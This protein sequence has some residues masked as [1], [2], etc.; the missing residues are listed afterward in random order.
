MAVSELSAVERALD[1]VEG[2]EDAGSI[3][4]A[5]LVASLGKATLGWRRLA[6][7]GL[8]L[9]VEAARVAVGGSRVEPARRDLRFTDPT[10]TEN[11]G[12]RRVK[13]LY[14]AWSQAVEELVDGADVEWRTKERARF[15][16]GILISAL[17]PTNTLAGNPAALKRAMETGGGSLLTGATQW[18]GDV[19][20]NG[21]MPS[22]VDASGFTVGRTSRDAGCR[23]LPQRGDGGAAVPRP[24]TV[25]APLVIIPPQINKCSPST[26]WR[27]PSLSGQHAVGRGSQSS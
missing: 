17:A 22:Q 15:A 12:Y 19:I 27:G 7:A 25:R 18:L 16:A 10:W 24:P 14:L 13:Q 8:G 9:S 23:R 2:G 4:V 5:A 1:A 20:R 26:T 11:P 21:G 3:D 6:R